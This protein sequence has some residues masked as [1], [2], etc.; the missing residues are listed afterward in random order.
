VWH[1]EKSSFSVCRIFGEAKGVYE[2]LNI[3]R[4]NR[5]VDKEK[6]AGAKI[7]GLFFRSF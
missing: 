7:G 5:Y 6:A 2:A 4:C 3:N 1:T